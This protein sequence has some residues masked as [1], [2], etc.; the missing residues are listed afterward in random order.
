[1][2]TF[3]Q[4]LLLLA[5]IFGAWYWGRMSLPFILF[6]VVS[7]GI[8]APYLAKGMFPGSFK[9]KDKVE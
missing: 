2:K 5:T 4:V 3:L 8:V 1:M 9:Q 7:S 6:I